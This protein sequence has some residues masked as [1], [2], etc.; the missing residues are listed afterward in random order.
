MKFERG[1][2]GREWLFQK[3]LSHRR[4]SNL[5]ARVDFNLIL[6]Y[7]IQKKKKKICFIDYTKAFDCVDHNKL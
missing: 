2:L 3:D 1:F 4:S 7:I 6:K 5:S